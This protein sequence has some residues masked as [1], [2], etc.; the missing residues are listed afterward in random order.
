M[1]YYEETPV[2][3]VV[4]V[5]SSEGLPVALME[6]CSFGFPCIATEVGGTPEAVR[7]GVT[8]CLLGKNPSPEEN[9]LRAGT[10]GPLAGGRIFLP[11]PAARK[12]WEDKFHAEKNYNL[13]YQELSQLSGKDGDS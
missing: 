11:L 6:A 2:S 9:C 8:G 4:N 10:Y 13:F 1:H 7:D 3:C 12:L 5:S